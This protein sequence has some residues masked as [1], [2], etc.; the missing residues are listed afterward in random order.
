MARQYKNLEAIEAYT[1]DIGWHYPTDG[2]TQTY[3]LVLRHLAVRTVDSKPSTL[4]TR[5]L[6]GEL[7]G[8]SR[9]VLHRTLK[10]LRDL[11]I[12]EYQAKSGSEYFTIRFK[13]ST[14]QSGDVIQLPAKMGS[15]NKA[16]ILPFEA[17][18]TSK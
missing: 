7:M 18:V 1:R 5:Q 15:R 9:D 17:G 14:F 3:L 10:R 13:L 6:R 8:I 11:R 4:N 2:L 12:I 16:I